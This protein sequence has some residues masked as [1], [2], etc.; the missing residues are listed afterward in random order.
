M[1]TTNQTP[2][3]KIFR[4]ALKLRFWYNFYSMKFLPVD[5]SEKSGPSRSQFHRPRHLN[6]KDSNVIISQNYIK[7]YILMQVYHL[8]SSS[9]WSRVTCSPRDS[10]FAGSNPAEIDGFFQVVK[11]LITIPPGG[12]L[13]LGSRVW[14][15]RFVKEPQTW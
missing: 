12:T 11:I 10:R 14:D 4:I 1:Y 6:P 9:R 8:K 3:P 13:S 15:F 5:G 7:S 2:L